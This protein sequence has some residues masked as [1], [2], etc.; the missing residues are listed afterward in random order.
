MANQVIWS[1]AA[2]KDLENVLDYLHSKWNNRVL[3]RFLNR[4]DDCVGIIMEDP[5]IFPIINQ[6]LNI[7]KCVV[8]MHNTLYYRESDSSIQIIRLFDSRQDPKKLVFK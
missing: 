4:I 8:T 6:E 3:N 7:R 5:K 1:P 2:E